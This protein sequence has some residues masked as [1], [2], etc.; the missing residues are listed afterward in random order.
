M[1]TVN[2]IDEPPRDDDDAPSPSR[3]TFLRHCGELAAGLSLSACAPHLSM[4]GTGAVMPQLSERE[5]AAFAAWALDAARSAGATYADVRIT[6]ARAQRVGLRSQTGGGRKVEHVPS[7]SDDAS[8]GFGV[9]V[10]AQ[11]AWGFAAS[12]RVTR[13][14]AVRVATLAVA[15]AKANAPLR[16]EPVR[17][18]PNPAH[19]ARYE[20]PVAVDPFSVPVGEKLDLMRRVHA[21]AL[22]VPK[23]FSARSYVWQ[24]LEDRFFASSEGSAITQRIVQISPSFSVSALE[25]G[26][27]AKQRTCRPNAITGGYEA[28]TR[29]RLLDQAKRVAEEAAQHLAAPSV[30]AGPKD[31]VLLPS[32][33]GLTIHE[34]IGHSTELDRAL[35]FEANLAGTSFLTPDKLGKFRVGAELCNFFGDRTRPESLSTCGYDD[36][37]V[38]TREFPIIRN[39]I[40]VGFQTIRAEAHLVGQTESM[41]CCYADSYA[42]VPFQRMPNVWLAPAPKA[43]TLQ[44]LVGG[45][46]DGILIDGRGSY[47]IDQQRYNFQFGG[48]AFWEIKGGKVRGMLADVAYQSRTPDFW[49]ACDGLGGEATW[50][51]VGLDADGKGEP[52]QL[53]SMSHG[54]PPARLR[55]M[56]V[57]RTG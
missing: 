5:R 11:G 16:D 32:H 45:V 22:S 43:V 34:S 50:E 51:N 31:L 53:N 44:D 29:A 49:Q 1:V 39:G 56:S 26:K 35:G 7:V 18:A 57:L 55:K 41:G 40:F 23:T 24:R 52:M 20:T 14:E 54:C 6:G 13:E 2:W 3:R 48:D 37:G 42:S 17:L 25:R 46:E 27:R 8:F 9:R 15:I 10:I 28:V 38:K 21:A 33:L 47:S 4:H 36:D 19:V 30:T 12:H